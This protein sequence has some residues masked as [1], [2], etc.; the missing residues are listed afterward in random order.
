MRDLRRDWEGRRKGAG[1]RGEAARRGEGPSTGLKSGGRGTQL[2]G[3]YC[4]LMPD[5]LI[6]HTLELLRTAITEVGIVKMDGKP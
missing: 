3:N 4:L 5:R 6:H 2:R 1:K